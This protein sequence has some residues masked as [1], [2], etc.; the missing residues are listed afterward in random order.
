[1]VRLF[2]WS[3]TGIEILLR[4][5]GELY[6]VSDTD[7]TLSLPVETQCLVNIGGKSYVIITFEEKEEVENGIEPQSMCFLA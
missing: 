5:G 1:M 6:R 7:T 3:C 4:E 2:F